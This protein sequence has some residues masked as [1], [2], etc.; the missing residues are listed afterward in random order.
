MIYVLSGY[1]LQPM[2][3][4]W[5]L[6]QRKSPTFSLLWFESYIENCS[7]GIFETFCVS[8]L[9]L[10]K[11]GHETDAMDWFTFYLLIF[12]QLPLLFFVWNG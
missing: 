5:V 8:K 6:G 4:L 3:A 7:G 9:L 11:L 1:A 10:P 2:L 12:F